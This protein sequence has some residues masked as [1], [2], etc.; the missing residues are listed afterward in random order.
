MKKKYIAAAITAFMLAGAGL[1]YSCTHPSAQSPLITASLRENEEASN[2]VSAGNND[3]SG[4]EE[5]FK[6][7]ATQPVDYPN[8]TPVAQSVT[9]NEPEGGA[10]QDAPATD[11][12]KKHIYVHICGAV[13]EPGVYRI[14]ADLRLVD[15]IELAG[16]LSA[17]AAGDSI[18]QAKELTDGERIYVPTADEV[19]ES[20]SE[21][22]LYSEV[23]DSKGSD[24]T[25]PININRAGIEELI[26]LPGIGKAK[27]ESIIRYRN[28]EG[29]FQFVEE[30][31][32][33]PGIKEGLFKQISPYITIN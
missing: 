21:Q 8:D 30:L 22:Y 11:S 13:N 14:S 26:S 33:I 3:N 18:N 23:L 27:A 7:A 29:S 15:I 6:S 19:K 5:V 24:N 25:R 16:G 20:G 32:N 12:S 2:E 4:N 31:M 1:L 9:A 17:D 28:E 10:G